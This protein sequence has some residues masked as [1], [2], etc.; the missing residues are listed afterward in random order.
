LFLAFTINPKA[1]KKHKHIH[2]YTEHAQIIELNSNQSRA[3]FIK[4][5][6]NTAAA[7]DMK[8]DERLKV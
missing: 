8:Y 6:H 3:P 1:A 4:P 5:N 2:T 7:A